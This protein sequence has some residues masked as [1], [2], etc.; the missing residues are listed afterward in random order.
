MLLAQ[1]RWGTVTLRYC[2]KNIDEAISLLLLHRC[3]NRGTKTIN[4]PVVTV[5][6]LEETNSDSISY[7]Y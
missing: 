3:H 5:E 2:G 1:R 4:G 6:K 7:R